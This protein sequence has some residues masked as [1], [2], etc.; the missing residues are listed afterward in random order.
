MS[1][2]PEVQAMP[3]SQPAKENSPRKPKPNGNKRNQPNKHLK[4]D[5][6]ELGTH[7]FPTS[8]ENPHRLY[9]YAETERNVRG[10]SSRTIKSG[11]GDLRKMWEK[12]ISDPILAI[13][14]PEE[15]ESFVVGN[16]SPV[17]RIQYTEQ[18][19]QVAIRRQ[20]FLNNLSLTWDLIWGQCTLNMRN[21]IIVDQDFDE[22]LEKANCV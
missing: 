17:E 20:V 9:S 19:K 16:P 21:A 15:P 12:G 22:A 1:N 13:P 6:S 7:V 10:L 5:V 4:G 18:C 2:L 8:D 14:M 3:D 11:H